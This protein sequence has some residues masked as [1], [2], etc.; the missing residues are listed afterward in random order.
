[1]RLLFTIGLAVAAVAVVAVAVTAQPRAL[2]TTVDER[3][4]DERFEVQ[5]TEELVRRSRLRDALYFVGVGWS[6]AMMLGLLVTGASARMRDVAA[7][8]TKKPFLAA[9]L[10]LVLFILA[11]T[12]LELPLSYYS[13]FV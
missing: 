8:V 6:G 10:Y 12:L 1:M 7:R 11:T 9:M 3:K 13:G 5:S 4:G 2:K